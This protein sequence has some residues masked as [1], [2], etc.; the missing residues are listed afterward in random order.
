M[1]SDS[2]RLPE[3]DPSLGEHM[4]AEARSTKR[5]ADGPHGDPQRSQKNVCPMITMTR[6]AT[7]KVLDFVWEHGAA[8]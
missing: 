5:S 8:G 3:F 2:T 4:R 6:T 7:E 1:R